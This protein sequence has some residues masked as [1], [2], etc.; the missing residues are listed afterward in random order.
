MRHIEVV[1]EEMVRDPEQRIG[2]LSMLGEE[3]QQQVLVEWNR[4]EREYPG[5]RH[6]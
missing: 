3:E 4:T 1:V 6:P 2:E 5:R